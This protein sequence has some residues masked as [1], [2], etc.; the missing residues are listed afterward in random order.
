MTCRTRTEGD[1]TVWRVVV[2]SNG[3]AYSTPTRLQTAAASL[4]DKAPGY[5]M[6]G[7]RVD[8]NDVLATYAAARRAVERARAGEGPTLLE[9]VTYRRLGH[10]QHDDQSYQPREEIDRWA[11]DN[12]PLDRYVAALR[13]GDV[14]DV[15]DLR[16]VDEI[17]ATEIEAAVDEA[18]RSPLPVAEQAR[19]DVYGGESAPAPW[20]R[21]SPP[22]PSRA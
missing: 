12:D 14:V 2:E 6:A 7:E 3:Y 18:E 15:D 20:T 17:V 21:L 9:V 19:T 13:E 1:A 5:G 10:A 16:E 4:V 8:G 11:R 22:D